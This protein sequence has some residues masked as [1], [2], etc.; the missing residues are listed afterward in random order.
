MIRP[1]GPHQKGLGCP[2]LSTTTDHVKR[3]SCIVPQERGCKMRTSARTWR[4]EQMS[5]FGT[6]TLWPFKYK[7]RPH[8]RWR[9]LPLLGRLPYETGAK[10]QVDVNVT[11]LK[12]PPPD[13]TMWRLVMVSATGT[14]EREVD[15][16]NIKIGEWYEYDFGLASFSGACRFD[17]MKMHVPAGAG[18]EQI[19]GYVQEGLATIHVMPNYWAGMAIWSVVLVVIAGL[20]SRLF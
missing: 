18:W 4:R 15:P 13:N 20:V 19:P 17:V 2:N 1:G 6:V 3:A 14:Q 10:L 5:S 8:A 7:S 9:R 11:L 12:A 16:K